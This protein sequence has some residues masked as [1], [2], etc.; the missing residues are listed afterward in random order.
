MMATHDATSVQLERGRELRLNNRLQEAL[1]CFEAALRLDPSSARGH[2][3]YGATLARMGETPKALDAY[4]ESLRIQPVQP[5]IYSAMATVY[6]AQGNVE[7]AVDCFRQAV[8]QSPAD[9]IVR[10]NLLYALNFDS[11]ATPEDV[12]REHAEFGRR[13]GALAGPPVPWRPKRVLQIGY[14]SADFCDHAVNYAF[15][16][17][18]ENHRRSVFEITLYSSTPRPDFI[19]H[20]LRRYASRWRDVRNKSDDEL[21]RMVRRDGIDILVDLAGHTSIARLGVFARKPAPVQVN[22]QGYPNTSGLATMDYRITDEWADPPGM[23]EHCHTEKL[24]RLPGGFFCFRPED[25]APAVSRLP[26]R[27]GRPITFGSCSKPAKWNH[28]VIRTWAAILRGVPES[29]LLLHHS[30]TGSVQTRVLQAFLSHGIS[31]NRIGL[32]G[33]LNWKDHWEWF[34]Q[35]DLALDPFPYNGTT[36]SC[37]TLWMGVPFVALAGRNHVARVGVSL[38]SRIG[39]ERLVARD[40]DE[41]AA[42]AIRLA[43]D[44]EALSSLRA[45]MRRRLE[46]STLLDC[47]GFTRGLEAAYRQMWEHARP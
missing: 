2:A 32:T 28:A 8:E 41:Y 6:L 38:L 5:R 18:L 26:L 7:L 43:G 3:G 16:P 36:G 30:T 23:T 15:E 1:H 47:R 46:R 17:V 11:R 45:G 39:L 35:V 14:V 9:E 29:R 44:R 24:V 13:L 37:E 31:P 10:S 22:F 20:R 27:E 34:Q 40:E 42:L 33:A 4:W 19:T 25:G 21:A 12:F